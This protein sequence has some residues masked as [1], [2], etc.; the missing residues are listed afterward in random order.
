LPIQTPPKKVEHDSAKD[1]P[2]LQ[3]QKPSIAEK[4]IGLALAQKTKVEENGE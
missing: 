2:G 4:S 3:F 1:K